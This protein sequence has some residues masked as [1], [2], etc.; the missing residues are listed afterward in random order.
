ME[1][2]LDLGFLLSVIGIL[3]GV[4][5]FLYRT[6]LQLTV[7]S[8]LDRTL[9]FL[10][11]MHCTVSAYLLLAFFVFFFKGTGGTSSAYIA[12]ALP[13]VTVIILHTWPVVLICLASGFL[14][15][16]VSRDDRFLTFYLVLLIVACL[17]TF[18]YQMFQLKAGHGSS[19]VHPFA[20]PIFFGCTALLSIP[21]VLL[22]GFFLA[23]VS[24][25]TD[26]EFYQKHEPVIISVI[27]GGY[28][29][30]PDVVTVTL[31]LRKQTGLSGEQTLLIEP[32]EHYGANVIIIEF[33]P[34]VI[35]ILRVTSR[36]IRMA[37]LRER[38]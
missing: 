26:K 7:M 8:P 3:A 32:D 19:Q 4:W 14:I 1:H 12:A 11:L 22:M 15:A 34:P 25:T 38:K 2:G 28:I 30:R 36:T 29:L 10:G 6:I 35:P 33:K 31:G 21:Y 18:L 5:I 13:V 27:P 20:T 23:D 24:I 17:T 9:L 16:K 37:R